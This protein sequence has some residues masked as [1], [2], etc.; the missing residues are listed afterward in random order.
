MRVLVTGSRG[1]VGRAAARRLAAAGHEVTGADL[2]EPTYNWQPPGTPRYMKV[3]L[4]HAGDAY[5]LIGNAPGGPGRAHQPFD[6]VVHAAAIPAPGQHAPHVVFST[7]VGATFNVVEACVRWG[8]RRLVNI[9]SEAISGVVFAERRQWP[10]YLPVD[11]NLPLRP[12]DPYALSKLVGEEIC[13]AAVR[14]SDLRCIS[15]RPVWVQDAASYPVNIAPQLADRSMLS[16]I[17]WSYVDVEDLADAIL[18]SVESELDGHEVFY[19]AAHGNVGDRDLYAAWRAAFPDAPT[20]L[21]PLPRPDASPISTSKAE[22]LLGWHP[23]RTWRDHLT[24]T[25]APRTA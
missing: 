25:G 9:S 6:A 22:R 16:Q 14:R 11:E 21:R 23:T 13:E 1:R 10:D 18:L 12:Q 20:E 24:D 19:I 4:T 15:L 7:N 3:D 8:V 2:A 17:G 5:A